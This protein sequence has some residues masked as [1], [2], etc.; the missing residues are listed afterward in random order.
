MWYLVAGFA[1]AAA[2]LSL[3]SVCGKGPHARVP[4]ARLSQLASMAWREEDPSVAP[5]PPAITGTRMSR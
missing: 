3:A 5:P 1:V 2:L 4:P